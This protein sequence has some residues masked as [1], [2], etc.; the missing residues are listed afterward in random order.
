MG[1]RD[2]TSDRESSDPLSLFIVSAGACTRG[3]RMWL[4]EERRGE[5]GWRS[6]ERGDT[7]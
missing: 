5:E 1:E 4:G 3:E 6:R 7:S 2:S